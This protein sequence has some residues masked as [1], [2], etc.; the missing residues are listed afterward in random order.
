MSMGSTLSG[1]GYITSSILAGS[2]SS[3]FYTTITTD[4]IITFVPIGGNA[5]SLNSIAITPTTDMKLKFNVGANALDYGFVYI[6]GGTTKTIEGFDI[7][8]MQVLG[9]SGQKLYFEATWF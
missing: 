8:N 4:E 5:V 3:G 6:T 1:N 7:D 9:A 2:D